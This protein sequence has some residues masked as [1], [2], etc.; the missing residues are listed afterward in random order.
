MAI[1]RLRSGPMTER[2]A[3]PGPEEQPTSPVPVPGAERDE[4]DWEEGR[5][6]AV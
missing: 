4:R 3:I 5:R 1:S 6:V 2:S